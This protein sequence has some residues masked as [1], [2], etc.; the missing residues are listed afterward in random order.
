[1][2]E[3]RRSID[4]VYLSAAEAML[5]AEGL[6]PYVLDAAT[7]S[8]E[9]SIWAIPRRL[10]IHEDEEVRALRLLEAWDAGHA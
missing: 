6:S 3:L 9:G 4:P 7:S 5:R 2:R 10:V 8:A 1:M